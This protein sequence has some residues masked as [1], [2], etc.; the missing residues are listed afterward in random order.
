M[1]KSLFQCIGKVLGPGLFCC[2][3]GTA[4]PKQAGGEKQKKKTFSGNNNNFGNQ[5]IE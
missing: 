5:L 2:R 3:R 4:L 1:T